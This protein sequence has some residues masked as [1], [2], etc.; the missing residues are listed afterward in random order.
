MAYCKRKSPKNTSV[1]FYEHDIPIIRAVYL[2]IKPSG[3]RRF[4]FICKLVWII[5][6]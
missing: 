3:L 4:D 6:E 5:N 2:V 1:H